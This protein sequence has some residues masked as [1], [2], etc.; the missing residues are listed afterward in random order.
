MARIG[1]DTE[2]SWDPRHMA[3]SDGSGKT[4]EQQLIE[5]A[6]KLKAS[7]TALRGQIAEMR[8]MLTEEDLRKLDDW[9]DN[10]AD[11]DHRLFLTH[12]DDD[13]IPSNIVQKLQASNFQLSLSLASSETQ[14]STG[15]RACT[16]SLRSKQPSPH[17]GGV[18][19]ETRMCTAEL[20]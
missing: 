6:D 3:T 11:E 10:L 15:P 17:K 13:P 4:P 5:A 16:S 14:R 7:T 9:W 20:P 2:G 19:N 18:L 8:T 1:A 12:R